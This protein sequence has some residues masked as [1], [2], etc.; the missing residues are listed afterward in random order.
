VDGRILVHGLVALKADQ[1]LQDALWGVC[2]FH[3]FWGKLAAGY[4]LLR[5]VILDDN[6][7]AIPP[8]LLSVPNRA[9]WLSTP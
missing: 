1:N 6:G 9:L 3:R 4:Y 5:H 7:P 2:Q 8:G